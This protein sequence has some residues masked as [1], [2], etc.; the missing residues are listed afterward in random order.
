[1]LVNWFKIAVTLV[2]VL[3]NVVQNSCDTGVP[4]IMISFCETSFFFF[5]FICGSYQPVANESDLSG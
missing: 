2:L 3:V 1:M 5:C 4:A